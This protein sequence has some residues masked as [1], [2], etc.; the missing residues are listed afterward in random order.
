M[1]LGTNEGLNRYDGSS[2]TTFYADRKDST[3]LV[4]NHITALEVG[5]D[6]QLYIGTP[7]GLHLY[8]N[9]KGIFKRILYKNN[10]AGHINQILAAQDGSL[11]VCSNRGL[12]MIK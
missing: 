4:S 12:F 7:L 11:Y 9:Q 2:V 6:H 1:W 5:S 10:S 8:D 3:K